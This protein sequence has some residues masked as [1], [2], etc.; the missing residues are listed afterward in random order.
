MLRNYFKI[1]VRNLLKHRTFSAINIIGLSVGIACCVLLAL[2]IK[3]EFS[4][5]NKFSNTDRIYRIY[6]TFTEDGVSERYPRTSPPIAIALPD[7]I[8]EVEI[9]TR[10]INPP[11]VEQHLIK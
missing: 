11:E 5:E 6:T 1:A 3:D 4:Y 7:L 8:P 10:V 2:Y 9:A